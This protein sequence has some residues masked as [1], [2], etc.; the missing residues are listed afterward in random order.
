M[1]FPGTEPVSEEQEQF[2]FV[3]TSATKKSKYVFDNGVYP[4]KIVSLVAGMS[5]KGQPQF[6]VGLV[7]TGGA[8]KGIDYKLSAPRN[9][10]PTDP[11]YSETAENPGSTWKFDK[12]LDVAG[13]PKVAKGTPRSFSV[14]QVVGKD[15]G[16]KLSKS[17]YNG[18]ERM[19]ADAVLPLSACTVQAEAANDI[20]F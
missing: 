4:A 7:G 2:T 18:K 6:I 8:A 17:E 16:L 1:T 5:S 10:L 14:S 9:W 15:V 12:V 11:G 3:D 13:V 19:S 20:P